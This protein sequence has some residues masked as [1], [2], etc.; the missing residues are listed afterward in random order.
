MLH[1]GIE[2]IAKGTRLVR[3]NATYENRMNMINS[4]Q[5][6]CDDFFNWLDIKNTEPP[7]L[8]W[9]PGHLEKQALQ[10][11]Q[12]YRPGFMAKVFIKKKSVLRNY[13]GLRSP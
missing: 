1:I 11:L 13:K 8:K 2:S 12:N 6:V 3:E 4:I 7:F 5:K 9:R 10:E